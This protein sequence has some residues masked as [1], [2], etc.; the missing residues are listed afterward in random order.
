MLAVT[1]G[2]IILLSTPF[3]RQG[4]F[5]RCFEDPTFTSFHVSSEDC[6]RIS[7]EFLEQEKKRMSK[8]QYAQEYL[9]MF[10]DELRRFFP[11]KLIRECMMRGKPKVSLELSKRYLGVD[12]AQ[13]G[14]DDT[15]LFSLAMDRRGHL[16]QFD[17]HIS[18]KTR[19]T[20]TTQL[21]LDKDRLYNYHR[22]FIDDQ[23]LG[24]G[25][26]DPLLENKQTR[27]RVIP[28]NNSSRP[29]DRDERR[30]KILKEDL[31]N[32]LLVLMEQG[33]ITIH[34]DPEIELSLRSVQVEYADS[35]KMKI[36][37]SYTHIAEAMIRSAWGVKEK[38]LNIFIA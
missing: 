24:S 26:F 25:V 27:R 29:L 10:V 13:M 16:Y 32:N 35:G 14:R 9:G 37:G 12:V 31:Y 30:K 20:D 5:F 15:V 38:G 19:L 36:F 1:K 22:I 4:Y 21:I 11:N 6:P 17:M 3:G 33:N 34:N 2:D 23:G 28:I 18:N 8:L 7:E